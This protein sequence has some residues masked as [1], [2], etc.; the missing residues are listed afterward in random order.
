MLQPGGTR[1]SA[2][3]SVAGPRWRQSRG[4]EPPRSEGRASLGAPN[5]KPK[6]RDEAIT[7]DFDHRGRIAAGDPIGGEV[8]Q[9]PLY[10]GAARR[11]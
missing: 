9:D 6:N 7:A 11:P 1:G 2:G 4:P 5:V 10:P 8:H 3:W